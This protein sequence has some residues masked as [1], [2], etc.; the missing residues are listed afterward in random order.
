VF[1]LRLATGFGQ[2]APEMTDADASGRR[3]DLVT[4]SDVV[5]LGDADGD[6]NTQE[7]LVGDAVAG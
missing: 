2:S 6:G 1:T 4:G 7:L 3:V 5:W